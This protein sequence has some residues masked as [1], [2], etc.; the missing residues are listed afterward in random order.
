MPIE[1]SLQTRL[2]LCPREILETYAI[3][4][5]FLQRFPQKLALRFSRVCDQAVRDPFDEVPS[6]ALSCGREAIQSG[7]E[8][9]HVNRQHPGIQPHQSWT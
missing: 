5:R 1:V 3:E 6:A 4:Q 2:E 7:V 9:W 8:F